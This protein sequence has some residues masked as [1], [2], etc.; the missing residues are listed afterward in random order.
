MGGFAKAKHRQ[1]SQQ[2]RVNVG[3]LHAGAS[4]LLNKVIKTVLGF[5]A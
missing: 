5:G 4:G 2:D 1:L 3:H